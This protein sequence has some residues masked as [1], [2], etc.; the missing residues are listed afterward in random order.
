MECYA[1]EE[2]M[3]TRRGSGIVCSVESSE[4]VRLDAEV[5]AYV[6]PGG[7]ER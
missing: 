3:R 1:G 7:D 2:S 5:V 4:K 6:P